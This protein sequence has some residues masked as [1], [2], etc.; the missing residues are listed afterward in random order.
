[1]GT[2]DCALP[3]DMRGRDRRGVAT[4]ADY[5]ARAEECERLAAQAVSP[6]TREIMTYLAH[7]WRTLA[8]EGETG[9][10]PAQPQGRTPR[11]PRPERK[12]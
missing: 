6:E 4:P 12:P 5:S 11:P 2:G 8:A 9:T 10:T 1:L 3:L 7:R